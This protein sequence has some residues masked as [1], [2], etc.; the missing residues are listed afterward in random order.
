MYSYKLR[1]FATHFQDVFLSQLD[2]FRQSETKRIRVLV[3]TCTGSSAD[4]NRQEESEEGLRP[5]LFVCTSLFATP[6]ALLSAP[7]ALAVH[8]F[9]VALLFID[10]PRILS[11]SLYLFPLGTVEATFF[12]G[13][14]K[15]DRRIRHGCVLGST[16]DG[17]PI[18]RICRILS[19][20]S[21]THSPCHS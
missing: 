18:S 17:S 1:H 9:M 20:P 10:F 8:V 5:L 3:Q 2:D 19:T 11:C 6:T 7:F 14:K 4:P 13:N 16:V 15:G 21:I 12:R